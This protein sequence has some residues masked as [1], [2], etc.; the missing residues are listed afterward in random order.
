MKHYDNY[1]MTYREHL[2]KMQELIIKVGELKMST[3]PRKGGAIADDG[4]T[5][6]RI[7]ELFLKWLPTL[8][9]NLPL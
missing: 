6:V 7:S 3:D 8:G 9:G 4:Q 1:T 5:K 2:M